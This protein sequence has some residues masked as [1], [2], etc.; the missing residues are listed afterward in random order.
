[1]QPVM[2][3]VPVMIVTGPVGVGKTTVAA[4][5][6][7]LLD[8]AA[9]PHAMVDADHLRWCYPSP[10]ADPF[11]GALGLQNLAAVWA[12]YREAGA[13][14]LVLADVVES[15][16]QLADYRAA[17]PGASLQ[18][19]RLT[20]PLAAIERRLAGRDTGDA[21]AWHRRRAAELAAIMARNR[22]EDLLIE[23]ADRSPAEIAREALSCARWPGVPDL[24]DAAIA[25]T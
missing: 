18:V 24:A 13:D 6:S 11:R 5:V 12:N 19:V 14:R 21:L 4:A 3:T 23:T 9:V 15:R 20:A 22:V 25:A 8:R 10:P 2:A 7:D 17:V 16:D 1:M